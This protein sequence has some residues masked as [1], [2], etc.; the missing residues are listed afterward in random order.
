MTSKN[1]TL[2]VNQLVHDLSLARELTFAMNALE[3]HKKRKLMIPIWAAL[4]AAKDA[5]QGGF[6]RPVLAHVEKID[7]YMSDQF[8]E[9]VQQFIRVAD[10][11]KKNH[12]WESLEATHD[13]VMLLYRFLEEQDHAENLRKKRERQKQLE[14][15]K[16]P[17]LSP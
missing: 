1:L 6:S 4:A 10:E 12:S 5:V 9:M 11:L 2:K 17:K 8:V 14:A 15:S 3:P 13:C 16:V 7:G